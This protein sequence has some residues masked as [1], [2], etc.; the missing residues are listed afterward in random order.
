MLCSSSAR[1]AIPGSAAP[2]LFVRYDT[3]GMP[4]GRAKLSQ[5]RLVKDLVAAI[6]YVAPYDM[7]V[8]DRV[9]ASEFHKMH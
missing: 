4:L 1:S 2:V 8:L 7:N 9:V 3:L 6:A 5:I